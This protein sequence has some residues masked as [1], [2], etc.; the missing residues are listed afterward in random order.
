MSMKFQKNDDNSLND[1]VNKFD[2][3]KK[4]NGKQR[5]RRPNKQTGDKRYTCDICNSSFQHATNLN[6]HKKVVHNKN[7][8]HAC[9]D[10]DKRFPT[11]FS[12]KRH[13]ITHTGMLTYNV[14]VL[15]TISK[16]I[17]IMIR[18]HAHT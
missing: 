1:S 4:L 17:I 3:Q 8:P 18:F 2:D 16:I 6:V 10:C 15:L 13:S 11:V 5:K 14:V 12:L 9:K 7:R